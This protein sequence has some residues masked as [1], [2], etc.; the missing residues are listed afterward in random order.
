MATARFAPTADAPLEGREVLVA[1]GIGNPAAFVLTAES[2]GARVADTVFFR[3]HHHYTAADAARLAGRG[4]PVVVTE[5]DAVKLADLWTF[6]T[7]L[8]VVRIAV[9]MLEGG[10]E[11]D[12]V[13]D[14]VCT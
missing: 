11:L 2:M 10:A 13:L 7:P 1:C 6:D 9:E 3:D 4:M 8:I 5:K 14:R 12:A